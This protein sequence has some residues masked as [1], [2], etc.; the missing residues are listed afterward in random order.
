LDEGGAPV[1][2]QLEARIRPS[3]RTLVIICAAIGMGIIIMAVIAVMLVGD[4]TTDATQD[5]VGVLLPIFLVLG[6]AGIVAATVVRRSSLAAAQAA[7][8]LEQALA[9]LRVGTI[10][11]CAFS[12]VAAILGLVWVLLSGSL[13]WAPVFFGA[14]FVSLA[15]S[16]PRLSQWEE[17]LV[18]RAQGPSP[19]STD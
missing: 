16:V 13:T 3:Y 6:G 7:P 5:G 9:R 17:V 2:P 18:T 4:V 19:V 14:A 1:E 8:G 15:L 12:E 10:L 11:A